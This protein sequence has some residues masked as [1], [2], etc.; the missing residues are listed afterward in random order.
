ML[1]RPTIAVAAAMGLCLTAAG[2][3]DAQAKFISVTPG[4]APEVRV[5]GS[6]DLPQVNSAVPDGPKRVRARVSERTLEAYARASLLALQVFQ[7]YEAQARRATD[8]HQA[9]MIAS[10]ANT[11]LA[12]VLNRSGVMDHTTFL[13]M[14]NALNA[15]DRLAHR[16]RQVAERVLR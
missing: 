15:D 16:A 13:R 5:L 6:F 7:K 14:T 8:R 1:I 9:Q 10:S 3:A 11:E 4:A 12:A 2:A